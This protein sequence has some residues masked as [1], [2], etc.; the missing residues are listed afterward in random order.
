VGWGFQFQSP[1]FVGVMALVLFAVGLNLSVLFAIGGSVGAGQAL[2]GRHGAA[3]SFFSGMLAVLVATPC[4]APFMGVALTA[5]LAGSD[6]LTMGVFAALGA[7]L[8]APYVLLACLPGLTSA[9]VPK[10]G[11]WMDVLRQGLAFPM[12]GGAIWLVWVLSIEAGPPGVLAVLVAAGLVGLA[13]W[14]VGLAQNAMAKRVSL[15][16]ALVALLGALGA[17]A[18]LIEAQPPAA[19]ETSAG[20][21]ASAGRETSAGAEAFSPARLADLARAAVV[22]E[23]DKGVRMYFLPGVAMHSPTPDVMRGEEIQVFGVVDEFQTATVILP[24]TH[25]KWVEVRDGALQRFSSFMT[26]EV[27][28]VLKTHSILGRLMSDASGE[29]DEQAFIDGVRQVSRHET[30]GL[31]HDIFTTRSGVL[32]GQLPAQDSAGRLS[33]LLIGHEIRDGLAAYPVTGRLLIVGD[34]FLARRYQRALAEFGITAELGSPLASVDG[35]SRLSA[36]GF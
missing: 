27:F 5:G 34:A 16:A 2:A 18:G 11:R 25:S 32:L 9:V 12:Y 35:F 23:A 1:L 3:G 36:L 33:G 6:A 21:Q 29:S 10:P 14:L 4:T 17:M 28:G 31:L 20:G 22:V 8:A 30:V 7:G 24:G 19:A 13:G 15:G 26:G